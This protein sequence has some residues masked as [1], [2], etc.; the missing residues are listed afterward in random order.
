[1]GLWQKIENIN[2]EKSHGLSHGTTSDSVAGKPIK[3]L[4]VPAP[5]GFTIFCNLSCV[6]IC[7]KYLYVEKNNKQYQDPTFFIPFETFF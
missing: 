3:L 1:M 4:E 6:I 7:A 5:N 2:F